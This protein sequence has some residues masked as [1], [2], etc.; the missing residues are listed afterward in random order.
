[1]SIVVVTCPSDCLGVA[2]GKILQGVAVSK[3]DMKGG[4][5]VGREKGVRRQRRDLV[6]YRRKKK[7]ERKESYKESFA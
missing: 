7:T 6:D 1:M 2:A 5:P 4:R 3:K